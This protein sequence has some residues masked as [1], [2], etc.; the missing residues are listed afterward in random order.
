MVQ[1]FFERLKRFFV[2][3]KLRLRICNVYIRTQPIRN[4]AEVTKSAG[5]V[6][7]ENISVLVCALATRAVRKALRYS[8]TWKRG[9]RPLAKRRIHPGVSMSSPRPMARSY[10]RRRGASPSER[11]PSHAP[12]AEPRNGCAPRPDRE[13]SAP[14]APQRSPPGG[15]KHLAHGA[16]IPSPLLPCGRTSRLQELRCPI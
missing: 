10:R 14:R 9:T 13:R 1:H 16:R 3:P 5:I 7:F 2:I 15:G 6:P 12:F 11:E 8:T 4:V